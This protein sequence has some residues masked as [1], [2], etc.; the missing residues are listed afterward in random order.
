MPAWKGIVGRGFTSGEFH[1]YVQTLEFVT[2]R[3]RFVVLHNTGEP[4]LMRWHAMPIE[5]RLRG[6]ERYYRDVRG[7]SGGPHLFVA[8]DRIWTFTPLTVPGVHSPSWNAD[9]LG[10]EIVGD[11]DREEFD[12][13]IRANTV[14]VLSALHTVLKLPPSTLKFHREDPL[15]THTNCPG[16]GIRKSDLIDEMAARM[17]PAAGPAESSG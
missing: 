2:W 8:D 17:T 4:T 12:S 15:T 16:S 1:C 5:R 14:S 11:Y 3:P 6:L 9:S 10:V 7:W 13:Q